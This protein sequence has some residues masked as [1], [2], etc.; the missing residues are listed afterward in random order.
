MVNMTL[1]KGHHA[2]ARRTARN[3]FNFSHNSSTPNKKLHIIIFYWERRYSQ[4]R[5]PAIHSFWNLYCA[6][7]CELGSQC[8][9]NE[10]IFGSG[11]LQGVQISGRGVY[12][13]GEGN[14]EVNLRATWERGGR[15]LSQQGG[16]K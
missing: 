6:Q 14:G 9:P 16:S 2:Q 11:K 15:I 8:R 10:C 7:S 3:S 12:E 13:P 4:V 5:F 1:A